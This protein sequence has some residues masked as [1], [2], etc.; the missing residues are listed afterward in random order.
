MNHF[1][2][3]TALDIEKNPAPLKWVTEGVAEYFAQ[4]TSRLR[5]VDKKKCNGIHLSDEL[6]NQ[7]DN[8]W[9]GYT[10]ML[11]AEKSYGK[12]S[13]KSFIQQSFVSTVKPSVRSGFKTDI[14]NFENGWRIF[15]TN[16]P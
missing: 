7:Y 8:Y 16:L 1:V 2:F 5:D 3:F 13:V 9:V 4:N 12:F 15:V 14:S 10:A 6:N 11:G